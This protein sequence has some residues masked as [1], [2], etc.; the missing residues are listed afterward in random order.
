MCIPICSLLTWLRNKSSSFDC[1]DGVILASC[2][3]ILHKTPIK[4]CS[5]VC[6]MSPQSPS[7]CPASP[8]LSSRELELSNNDGVNG[9]YD[10][11]KLVTL[12]VFTF[13]DGTIFKSSIL[14]KETALNAIIYWFG[15]KWWTV[16]FSLQAKLCS[17]LG[18]FRLFYYDC[19]ETKLFVAFQLP[20]Q[21]N[22]WH[23]CLFFFRSRNFWDGTSTSTKH[24]IT[25]T[26]FRWMPVS[27][28]IFCQTALCKCPGGIVLVSGIF[29]K[30]GLTMVFARFC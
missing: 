26:G 27:S 16:E 24:V 12:S 25:L 2:L 17:T 8:A 9:S 30:H 28:L 11:N 7:L 1:L 4:T 13:V 23:R 20:F 29:L 14:W 19:D 6:D 5:W 21:I 10:V 3:K 15:W 18:E 22:V